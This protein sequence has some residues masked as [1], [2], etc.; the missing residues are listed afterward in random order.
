[1]REKK[2]DIFDRI[3]KSDIFDRIS[4]SDVFDRLKLTPEEE[5]IF[6]KEIRE[7]LS[8]EINSKIPSLPFAE[9]FTKVIEK[10]IEKIRPSLSI[11]TDKIKKEITD[12]VAAVRKELEESADDLQKKFDAIQKDLKVKPFM[13]LEDLESLTELTM[14]ENS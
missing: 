5:I 7:L 8:E 1:M 13:P 3:S 10:Q 14:R 12:A 11:D 2:K 9:I 6:S 4:K